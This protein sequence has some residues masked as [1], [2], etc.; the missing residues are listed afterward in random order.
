MRILIFSWRDIA[1]PRSGGA[2]IVTDELARRWVKLGH[3]VTLLSAAFPGSRNT[4]TIHGVN[5]VRPGAFHRYSPI[6]YLDFLYRT[7]RYYRAHLAGRFD[8]VIDQVHGLPFW[9]LFW[10]KEPVVVFPLEVAGPIWRYE[11]PWPFHLVGQLLEHFYFWLYRSIPAITIS[12]SVKK[13]LTAHGLRQVSVIP[14]GNTIKPFRNL[15]KK[16]QYPT[17]INLGRL[18]PM[19]RIEQTLAAFALVLKQAP[20][21]RLTIVG[22]GR[23]AYVRRLKQTARRLKI[24]RSVSWRGYVSPKNKTALLRNAWLLVSTSLKEG[25]GLVVLEANACGTPAIVYRVPGLIDSVQDNRTGII[26][27]ENT[28]EFLASKI[29]KV[30]SNKSLRIRLSQNALTYSRQFDWNKSAKEALEIIRI[31]TN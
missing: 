6:Q 17:I 28:P 30:L 27:R 25:W 10:V 15:S 14:L 26:C 23:P 5:V 12:P 31:I 16:S 19:K 7:I 4:E 24:A 9:T 8:L 3:P 2:E 11:I 13:E 21:A 20:Q 18:V 1:H 22:R 29:I